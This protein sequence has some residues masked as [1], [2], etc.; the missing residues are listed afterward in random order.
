MIHYPLQVI[1]VY[2][3]DAG[4]GNGNCAVLAGADQCWGNNNVGQLGEGTTMS[5]SVARLVDP[6]SLSAKVTSIFD[7]RISCLRQLRTEA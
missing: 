4:R 6:G 5:S 7:G 3:V 1:P 2:K